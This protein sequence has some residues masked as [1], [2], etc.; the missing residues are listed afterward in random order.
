MGL[1]GGHLY[2]NIAPDPEG[3]IWENIF[4]S[5]DL[6]VRIKVYQGTAIIDFPKAPVIE[7]R[8]GK[9]DFI[10]TETGLQDMFQVENGIDEY[11]QF[12]LPDYLEN[13]GMNIG[14]RGKVDGLIRVG[15]VE[16]IPAV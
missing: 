14:H 3:F 7:G 4:P 1:P 6:V 13:A 11:A 9:G 12:F 5:S 15:D 10:L 8:G 16:E 2:P